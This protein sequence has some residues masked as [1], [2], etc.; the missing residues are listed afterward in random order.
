MLI[1]SHLTCVTPVC[2]GLK[3][4]GKFPHL[5]RPK[6]LPKKAEHR[7]PWKEQIFLETEVRL[8]KPRNAS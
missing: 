8:V 3:T 1:L 7:R 6:A 5:K 4:I 2:V